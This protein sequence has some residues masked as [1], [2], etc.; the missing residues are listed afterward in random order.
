VL[1]RPSPRKANLKLINAQVANL[2]RDICQGNALASARYSR[3]DIRRYRI[4]V[5]LV[6]VLISLNLLGGPSGSAQTP[7]KK[8]VLILNEL[9]PSHTLTKLIARELLTGVRDTPDRQVEFYSESFDMLSDPNSL[10][11][12]GLRES[13][14]TQYRNPLLSKLAF[15][16]PTWTAS[17]RVQ[18]GSHQSPELL[19]GP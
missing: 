3:F 13:L 7:A 2:L 12:S 6:L 17:Q 10:S 15:R 1:P 9:G 11:P 19:E 14:V 18:S 8:N 4:L 5:L 16:Q